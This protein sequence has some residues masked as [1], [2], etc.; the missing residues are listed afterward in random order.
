MD[1][2]LVDQLYALQ[3]IMFWF[4]EGNVYAL[5]QVLFR[6]SQ[7][8]N[9]DRREANLLSFLDKVLSPHLLFEHLHLHDDE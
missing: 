4:L 8:E 5:L 3:S 7:L 1:Q 2:I 6:C 9:W